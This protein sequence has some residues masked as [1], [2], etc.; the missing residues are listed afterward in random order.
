MDLTEL[1]CDVDDF[2]KLQ[3]NN[4]LEENENN[5]NYFRPNKLSDSEVMTISIAYHQSGYKNFKAFYREYVH[6][7]LKYQFPD[8]VS[9]N[10]FVELM[11]T[12][13]ASLTMYLVSKFGKN[14]GIAY[15]DSTPIQV[16]KSKRMS[17][18]KVFKNIATKAKSSIG[19]FFGFKVHL[20][21]NES[22]ELLSVQFSKANVDDRKPV[23]TMAKNIVGKLFGDKGYI[24]KELSDK[25]LANG[26]Q[27]IT[28][29][30][31]NMKNMLLS[32]VD[33]ILLRKRAIIETV[34]D[35]L[36]NI[37]NIEHTRHRSHKNFLVNL[38]CGLIAYA[39]KEKKP[40]ISGIDRKNL[41]MIG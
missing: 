10:R 37:S 33:K 20:I 30:K 23:L 32:V 39:I 26:V 24:S 15:V 14:T 19:W 11:S 36:K 25:L 35:Q 5:R 1:F 29:V 18:N 40:C 38:L 2:V 41:M 6:K 31:S 13:T 8:L 34:N 7:Y 3:N 22:G 28:N 12:V 17:R 16:C 9:Y 21:I 27:L 4:R